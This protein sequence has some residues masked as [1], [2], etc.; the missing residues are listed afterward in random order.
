MGC[1]DPKKGLA[2]AIMKTPIFDFVL[3]HLEQSKGTWPDL[4]IATGISRRTIEKIARREI[5][6][7]GIGHIQTLADHFG[8]GAP[9]KRKSA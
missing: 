1:L 4:S 6:N 8:Y 3:A 5:V 2:L 9:K 7:P